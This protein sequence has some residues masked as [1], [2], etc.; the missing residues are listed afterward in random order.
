MGVHED[1]T[2][3]HDGDRAAYERAMAD[4][5]RLFVVWPGEWSSH[6]FVIDDLDEYATAHGIQYAEEQTGLKEHVH[7]MRWESASY[8]H[9]SPRSPYISVDVAPDCGREIH[10]RRA[11]ATQMKEQQ[12][13]D[14]ATSEG[15]GSSSGAPGR[16]KTYALRV[17]RKSLT[18]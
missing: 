14:V 16:K 18:S 6:L 1:G 10:D 5:S 12:G 3:T 2:V 9:D 8:A 15:W 7:D 17:R 13:W 11:F 4:T